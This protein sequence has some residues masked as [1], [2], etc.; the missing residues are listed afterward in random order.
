MQD[1]VGHLELIFGN[2]ELA[3][4][5]LRFVFCDRNRGPAAPARRGR[6]RARGG[7]RPELPPPPAAGAEEGPQQVPS[8]LWKGELALTQDDITSFYPAHV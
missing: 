1:Q 4:P 8:I 6:H 2:S 7:R 5:S 3:P